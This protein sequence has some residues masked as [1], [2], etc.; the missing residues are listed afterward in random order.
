[1]N[2]EFNVHEIFLDAQMKVVAALL[3]KKEVIF[4]VKA[5]TA[6]L[7]LLVVLSSPYTKATTQPAAG[8]TRAVMHLAVISLLNCSLIG[9]LQ[10]LITLTNGSLPTARP[11]GW[12]AG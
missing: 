7:S 2:D 10:R 8:P 1:M 6:K 11:Q 3:K 9:P 12:L 5:D 4:R